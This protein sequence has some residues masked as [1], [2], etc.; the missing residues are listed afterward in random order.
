MSNDEIP[1]E[2]SHDLGEKKPRTP[3]LTLSMEKRN[4]SNWISFLFNPRNSRLVVDE[5]DLM[6]FKIEENCHVLVNQFHWNVCFKTLSCRKIKSVFRDVKWCFNASWRLK[7]LTAHLP[8]TISVAIYLCNM[9]WAC[10]GC[11]DC[12]SS[13]VFRAQAFTFQWNEWFFSAHSHRFSIL[14]S[15]SSFH[16][17]RGWKFK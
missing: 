10:S 13:H 12:R 3:T 6:W 14:E 17:R 2:Q 5:D 7:E 15:L 16:P 8:Q 9:Q 4:I 1:I 11:S